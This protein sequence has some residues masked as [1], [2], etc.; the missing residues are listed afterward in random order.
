MY[1]VLWA[2]GCQR[3]RCTVGGAVVGEF[4]RQPDAGG[5]S[6]A[7]CPAVFGDIVV[8][9]AALVDGFVQQCIQRVGTGRRAIAG[10]ITGDGRLAGEDGILQKGINGI[11]AVWNSVF[12]RALTAC[13]QQR[14]QQYGEQGEGW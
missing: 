2:G 7:V 5:A 13:A 1:C 6:R 4:Y 8:Q 3:F 9:N 11:L 10:K 12:W 14:T